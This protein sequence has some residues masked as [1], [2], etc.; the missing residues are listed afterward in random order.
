ME[1]VEA[2]DELSELLHV[3]S[4]ET[5]Y[6]AFQTLRRLNPNDPMVSGE[7]IEGK[8]AFHVIPSAGEPLVHVARSRRPEI[9]LFGADQQLKPPV[10]LSTG[11]GIVIKD[12][13]KGQL[14]VSRFAAGTDDLQM[15]CSYR[16][17]QVIRTVARMG[18]SYADVVELIQTAK[19]QKVLTSRIE[20]D[21]IPRLVGHD[22]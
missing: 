9:V 8:F 10:V 5:R 20:V 14:K 13:G 7:T 11:N 15:E 6:G 3:A 18:A 17:D 1:R 19:R 16:V 21:S 12:N 22:Q 2:H 4:A